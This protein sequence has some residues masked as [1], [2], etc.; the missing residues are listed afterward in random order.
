MGRRTYQRDPFRDGQMNP[1]TVVEQSA[2]D[3]YYDY[4]TV[5]EAYRESVRRAALTIKPRLKRATEDI[6][7]I[8]KELHATK[9]ML[10][11]GEYTQ[12][13]DIEFSLSERMAQRFVNVYDRLG[14]KTDKLSVLPPSTLYL[15][16][17]PS[18]PDAAIRAVEKQIERGK[19][20]SVAYV[21]Q[22]ISDA[23]LHARPLES[24]PALL[25]GE[26]SAALDGA[27]ASRSQVAQRLEA[28]L[29]T[30]ITLLGGQSTAD[31]ETLFQTDE[32]RI[33]CNE[34]VRLKSTLNQL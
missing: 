23:K 17:A 19:R 20:V 5:A 30:V 7:V 31:W 9:A 10:P 11:H 24:E 28:T 27:D 3:L 22:V 15:L 16:A 21:Q 14:P 2:V 1:V 13:L 18:T 26:R 6:F 8:G 25:A 33:V 34:L 29:A 32:L 4:N 12:W